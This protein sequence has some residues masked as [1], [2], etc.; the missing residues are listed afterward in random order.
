[1]KMPEKTKKSQAALEFLMTYGWAIMVVLA[2]IGALSYFGVLSPDK[3]F[4]DSCSF[5]SGVSCLDFDYSVISDIP[6]LSFAIKNNLGWDIT[7]VSIFPYETNPSIPQIGSISCGNAAGGASSLK[8]GGQSTYLVNCDLPLP[9]GKVRTN[10]VFTY[11]KTDTNLPHQ[12]K[13]ALTFKA[14]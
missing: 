12:I 14:K 2:A 11:T 13:G 4:P 8:N 1:M 5:P 9:K 6:T 7:G 3:L 10:L